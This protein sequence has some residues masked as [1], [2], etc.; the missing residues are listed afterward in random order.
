M[1]PV[2]TRE[3]KLADIR[4]I[5]ESLGAT[6]LSYPQYRDA[7]GQFSKWQLY[8]DGDSW[9]N[10]CAECNLEVDRRN[11]PISDDTYF[12]R[13][14]AFI[15]KTGRL[16]KTSEQKLAGLSFRKARW[17]TL[18]TFLAEASDKGII[19]AGLGLP[20]L[21]GTAKDQENV[22]PMNLQPQVAAHETLHG[23]RRIPPPPLQSLRANP[24]W[25][26]ID[27]FGL[28]YA[29]QD[30]NAV[31]ALFAILCHRGVIPWQ[32]LDLNGGQGVDCLC[33][34]DSTNTELRVEFKLVLSQNTWNHSLE[35]LDVVVCWKNS[36]HRFPKRV[37]ELEAV[38]RQYDI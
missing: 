33:Y 14:T 12:A 24:K 13:L 10:L 31:I 2:P 26:R 6:V 9:A 15:Q 27:V 16:P 36:W 21:H 3:E 38:V 32:I 8:A 11:A 20:S 4:R 17:P 34:D 25:K 29:P 23:S 30:E 7:G 37:L 35:D 18:K 28:P 19:P 5:R 1:R 22:I